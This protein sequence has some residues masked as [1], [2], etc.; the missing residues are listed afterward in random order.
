MLKLNFQSFRKK[1]AKKRIKMSSLLTACVR[2]AKREGWSSVEMAHKYQR[3]SLLQTEWAWDVLFSNFR[4]VG[5]ENVL[6]YGSGDGK[7][8]ALM[9]RLASKGTVKGVDISPAM[10]DFASAQFPTSNYP[11]LSFSKSE[12]TLSISN[13]DLITSFCVFHLIDKPSQTLTYFNSILKTK[14]KLVV[15]YPM[16]DP[17]KNLVFSKV[18]GEIFKKHGLQFSKRSEENTQIRKDE[19]FLRQQVEASGFRIISLKV[20]DTYDFFMTR[21]DFALWLAGTLPGNDNFPQHKVDEIASEIVERFV[22]LD[23]EAF[24]ANGWVQ[25]IGQRV[26]L[27]AEKI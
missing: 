11:N 22:E 17:N 7:I 8:S 19:T 15:T 10:V 27:I 26:D 5:N 2:Q 9:A 12:S 25:R 24:A 21:E 6:D 18:L 16:I 23:P 3:S 14:G 13:F 20:V 1:R 4:F